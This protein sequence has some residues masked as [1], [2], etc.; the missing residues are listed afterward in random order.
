MSGT[1]YLEDIESAR[2]IVATEDKA[3]S[4]SPAG[5]ARVTK[6]GA[7][8][9]VKRQHTLMDMFSSTRSSQGGSTSGEPSTKRL[10]LTPSGASGSS[11]SSLKSTNGSKVF[12]LQKLNSI[13]FSLG[14]YRESLT[15]D[16]KGLLRLECEVM[17]K[18]WLKLLKDEIKKPYFIEL[19][20]FLW[21]EGIRGPDG[22]SPTLRI[23]PAREAGS[24]QN[25][26]WE[27]FTDRVVD[28]V[29]KYGGANLATN[30][31]GSATGIGRGVVFLAWGAWAGKRV[32]KLNQV[33]G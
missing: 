25:K 21:E 28:V 33:S 15:E 17:G 30:G 11:S 5:T 16:Q 6:A 7:S 18:S 24:H 2:V 27:E 9:T 10:K 1:V 13:P 19:K 22:N 26:G 8:S 23:Y 20:K 3:P 31:A 29:D 4:S 14:S 32:A 12:G